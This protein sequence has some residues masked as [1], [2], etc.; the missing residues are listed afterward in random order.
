MIE[1]VSLEERNKNVSRR[2]EHAAGDHYDYPVAVFL[3]VFEYLR[4]SEEGKGNI[5]LFIF[6][7]PC[8]HMTSSAPF[9]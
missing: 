5:L 9:V 2:R 8:V 7:V 4:Q 6:C 3:Y 1:R